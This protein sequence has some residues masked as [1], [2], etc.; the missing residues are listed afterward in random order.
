[1]VQSIGSS[2]TTS[3][4][5]SGSTAAVLEAQLSKYQKQL[6][7]CV[8]CESSKT[9]EGKAQ[10]QEIST[11]ISAIKERMNKITNVDAIEQTNQLTNSTSTAPHIF[12]VSETVA[13]KSFIGT[14]G[15]LLDVTA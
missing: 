10:I 14:L 12:A 13:S 4:A 9:D 6:S 8:H 11:K 15:S 1:M 7:D 5:S 2:T 3:A